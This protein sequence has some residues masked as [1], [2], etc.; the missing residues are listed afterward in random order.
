MRKIAANFVCPIVTEPVQNGTLILDDDGK[1]VDLLD[2]STGFR[3]QES[4]E[5]YNGI[6][7]PGF[8]NSHCHLELSY[9]KNQIPQKTGLPGFL[10]HL[11]KKR[12]S[13]ADIIIPPANEAHINM[14]SSGIVAVGDT[15]NTPHTFKI[16]ENKRII[17][18]SFVEIWGNDPNKATRIY[19][20]GLDLMKRYESGTT[21]TVSLTPH[22]TYTVSDPLFS[23]ILN[24]CNGKKNT[25]SIHNQETLSE[26][27]LFYFNSGE[28]KEILEYLG[29]DLTEFKTGN[30]SALIC[31][32]QKLS[33]KQKVLLIHN[34]YTTEQEVLEAE[35]IHSSLFWILCPSAN[36]YIEDRLPNIPMLSKLNINL[37]LGTDS[38][39]SNTTLSI[40]EEMKRIWNYFPDIG[41]DKLL[42]WG[43]L[44]GAK[45]LD[46]DDRIG[47][48]EKGK[49]PGVNL[50]ENIDF[51]TL[52]LKENTKV[53][54]LV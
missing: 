53:K 37:A 41:L 1:I 6:L 22:A 21:Q 48:F 43:T 50:L 3:E 5:F 44:N 7:V 28:L 16:K 51:D 10:T 17:Y 14:E 19:S 40:L 15:T 26:N 36:L 45:T 4:V 29:D 49:K 39:A 33:S 42:L 52:G 2:G 23:E 34:T 9:L 25:I 24:Y 46:L 11:V 47:S 20:K 38:L 13:E 12:R 27:E 31:T 30:D 32:L 54:V 35:K 18:H 8:V